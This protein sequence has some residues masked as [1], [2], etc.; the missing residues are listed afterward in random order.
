MDHLPVLIVGAGP[1]GLMMAVELAR[2]DIPFRIIDKKPEAT[3][4]SN[5][6]WMQTRT[7]EIFDL[8]G[9]VDP[10]I[11]KGHRCDAVNLYTKGKV[12]L[13]LPFSYLD[14]TYPFILF[15]QQA[16]TEKLLIQH[17][18][19][20]K[21]R[22][23]RPLELIELR[24]DSGKV[25]STLKHPDGHTETLSSDWLIACDG[26]NSTVR[27]K[28]G[29]SLQGKD[30][31]EQFMVADA[32]M[33]SFFQ[34]NEVHVFFD[35]GTLFPE[36]GTLFAA[37]PFGSSQYRI[38]ANLYFK[39]PR[40][41][42]TAKEVKEVV[43][44][45]SY[46][47][48][49]PETVS[50]ISPFWIHDK[51]VDNLRHQSVFLVGDAGH[52]HSPVG[53]QGMNAGIQDAFNLAWKL[54]LVI[55]GKA[56]SSLLDSYQLERFPILNELVNLTGQLTERALFDP[57]FYEKLQD[58]GRAIT[59]HETD[60]ATRIG[61]QLTQLDIQYQD[62]PIISYQNLSEQSP[63]P[64]ERAPDVK[65]NSSARL[66]DYLRHTEHQVLLFTGSPLEK[67]SLAKLEKLQHW[68]MRTYPELVRAQIVS[69]EEMGSID[70]LIFDAHFAIHQAYKISKPTVYIIRPDNHIAYCSTALDSC[71]IEAFFQSYSLKE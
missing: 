7:L 58:F 25:I 53:G 62:S 67:D 71:E 64:G 28:L 60:L 23:E 40:Q 3:Q 2:R 6:T 24:Q 33:G 34:T 5:A 31:A 55:K 38:T 51:I 48:Y 68:L 69:K 22:V 15:L 63:K 61:R 14:S 9:L 12:A 19:K 35:A 54:A 39:Q 16:E 56:D 50:W 21:T 18:E 29:L 42:F 52:I 11:R 17:L 30:L 66:Y 41:T 49:T 32:E 26:A 37:F 13:N 8:L 4:T 44:E 47:N 59:K 10:F 46:A 36:K 65:M 1:S 45:R 20:L 43:A 57:S 27:Q 70:N